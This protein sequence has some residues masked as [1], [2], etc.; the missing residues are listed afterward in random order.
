MLRSNQ[1]S[2]IA[3]APH[4]SQNFSIFKPA[5]IFAAL[6]DDICRAN[7]L[8]VFMP[9]ENLAWRRSFVL[10]HRLALVHE[11]VHAF[12]LIFRGEQRVEQAALEHHAVVQ[13]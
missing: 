6:W 1:L 5:E 11:S 2:Y 4:Y 3:E 7:A 10:E 8:V 9:P 12:L 13:P